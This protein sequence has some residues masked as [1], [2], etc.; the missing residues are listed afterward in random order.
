MT[1]LTVGQYTLVYNA[2]SFTLA[3]MA[4]ASIFLWMGR[5]QVSTSYKTALTISGLVTAIAAYHYF[6][7]FNSW[8]S[9]YTLR[10]DALTATGFAFNDA[11]RYV[12]WLLTVPLLLIELILVMKLPQSETV[13]RSFRLGFAAVLMIGLGYPGEIAGD[14]ATR[15]LWGTLSTIP[16][17]YIVWALFK[18]LGESINRQPENVRGLIKS[19]R[20]LTFAS[21]GFY[22]LVYMLP[23]TGLSGGA[24]TTGVQIGY[25]FAD[26]ISKVGL[27]ILVYN[28]AVRKSA[29]ERDEP[30]AGNR[31][32][33]A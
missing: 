26:I 27:G 12:D 14:N 22:P 33:A 11:Y 7:I 19:A 23:Y 10:N 31:P 5:S 16:F 24:V 6:R 29:A 13:S 32:I 30:F 8:E 4:A 20:L 15:A 1:Q 18:G 17:I 25:T 2:F 21:W 28:I 3:T 9:A